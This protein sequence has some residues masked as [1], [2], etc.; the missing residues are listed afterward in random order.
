VSVGPE[1]AEA[2]PNLLPLLDDLDPLIRQRAIIALHNIGAAAKPAV[3]ALRGALKDKGLDNSSRAANALGRIGEPA[4][5]VL[6]EALGHKTAETRARDAQALATLGPKAKQAIPALTITLRD[7]D[8]W[9]R[10]FSCW[11]L[12]RMGADAKVALPVLRQRLKDENLHFRFDAA[13]TILLI[14]PR[15]PD[16]VAVLKDD[17]MRRT[18]KLYAASALALVPA[19]AEATLPILSRTLAEEGPVWRR[20]MAITGISRLGPK[21]GARAAPHLQAIARDARAMGRLRAAEA[22]ATLTGRPD[23]LLT[24]IGDELGSKARDRRLEGLNALARLGSTGKGLTERV[25]TLT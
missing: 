17:A 13:E 5:P 16:A 24:A 3:E 20:D 8:D 7:P 12:G 6:I 1:A 4:V 2:I 19:E 14:D 23:E 25:F 11:A 18:M 10:R 15:P 9:V 22:L 21:L